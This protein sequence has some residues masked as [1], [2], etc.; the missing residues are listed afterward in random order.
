MKEA[1]SLS[2][3]PKVC[4]AVGKLL[5]Q[6]VSAALNACPASGVAY[7]LTLAQVTSEVNA[8]ISSCNRTT[9]LNEADRLDNFNNMGCPL[10]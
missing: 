5:S 6:G 2:S 4:D 7:P 8:A 10:H 1:L 3:G 9:I